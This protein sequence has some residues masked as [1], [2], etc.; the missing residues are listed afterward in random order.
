[1]RRKEEA[2]KVK[3]TTRQS[4]TAHPRQSL[5]LE[6]ISCLGWD[7]NPHVHV[8]S[9]IGCLCVLEWASIA[10]WLLEVCTAV[11]HSAVCIVGNIVLVLKQYMHG[12]KYVYD[13]TTMYNVHVAILIMNFWE[14]LTMLSS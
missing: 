9:A 2:S 11:S 8:H 13:Y 14:I 4:N 3:Q 5:F 10:L 1:M 6:K 12:H 7:S